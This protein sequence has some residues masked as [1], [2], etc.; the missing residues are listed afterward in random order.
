MKDTNQNEVSIKL[1]NI[2]K[3]YGDFT[4]LKLINLEI[5]AGELFGFL[6]PNGAGKTT[7]IRILTGIIRQTAGDVIIYGNNLNKFPRKAKSLIGFVPDRPYLYEKLTPLEYF[8]FMGGLYSV[9][10]E[11]I[12]AKGQEMLEM[13]NL[14]ERRNELIE[15][16]SH[17][18]KQKVAMSAAV[19]HDPDIFVVDE[20]TV[21]L[22]PKSI[23]LAKDFFVKLTKMGKTVFLTTHTLSVAQDLCDRI[24]IINHGE[25]VALG[26]MLELKEKMHMKHANL[27]GIFLKITE[28]DTNAEIKSNINN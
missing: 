21:G 6:G 3:S 11:Q 28:E 9:D 19:L 12:L 15:S 23:R 4:A 20:P 2:T 22:D 1:D 5:S 13:F 7:L 26:S 25:I 27:E 17:G 8:D 14:W 18:M 10:S 16:F 24:A